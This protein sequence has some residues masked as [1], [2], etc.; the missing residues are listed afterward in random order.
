MEQPRY[1]INKKGAQDLRY[2]YNDLKPVI[3][4]AP[5]PIPGEEPS[6]SDPEEDAVEAKKAADKQAKKAATVKEK[7][8]TDEDIVNVYKTKTVSTEENGG[9]TGKIV[10]MA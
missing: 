9:D 3:G 6:E 5:A 2:N 1:I 4:Q 8:E 7:K 10:A